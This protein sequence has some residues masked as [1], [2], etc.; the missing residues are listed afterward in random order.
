MKGNARWQM[1]FLIEPMPPRACLS[2]TTLEHARTLLRQRY[3]VKDYF[4]NNAVV[5]STFIVI[6]PSMTSASITESN[7]VST[8][9][10]VRRLP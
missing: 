6:L 5:K 10:T 8:M 1:R 7:L 3:A 9:A 2:S 4:P